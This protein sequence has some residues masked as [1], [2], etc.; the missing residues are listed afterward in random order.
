MKPSSSRVVIVAAIAA[1]M[2]GFV[3]VA[4]TS[5]NAD[6]RTGEREFEQSFIQ[7]VVAQTTRSG[8]AIRATRDLRAGTVSG[9]HQGWMR[10]ETTLT[11]A[12][13]FTWTVLE[14]GGSDRTRE[15]V[16]HAMLET[17]AESWRD[18]DR[19]AAALTPTNYTF[20]P[21]SSGN[22]E[23]KIRLIPRREDKRLIDGVLTVSSDGYPLRLEGTLAKSPSFW[24]KSV[25]VVKRYGR[26]AGVALPTAL[27]S[28]AE[29]R[30]IG[31]STF[32]MRYEY[33]EVNGRR[34][35]TPAVANLN[36]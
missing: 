36:Q 22:G 20:K 7:R 6:T 31:K 11:P 26:F 32:T 15:K 25:R 28:T 21:L 35:A 23:V 19:D 5:V 13:R 3:A 34:F 27:E 4:S 9:K 14:E 2:T 8:L 16:F 17:E 29:L 12:G 10:V 24:V 33:R 30:F 1:V 18:G